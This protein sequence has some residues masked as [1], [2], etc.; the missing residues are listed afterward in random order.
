MRFRRDPKHGRRGE[1]GSVLA[2]STLGMLAFL[3]ATGLCVDVG[4]LYLAKN[5][6]QN[7]ADAAAL[8]GASA[9]NSSAAGITEAKERAKAAM[10]S[11][12]FN[13]VGVSIRDQDVTFA[14]NLGGP[15]ME[16]GNVGASAPSVRF[17]KVKTPP[18][19]V[20]VFFASIV[21]G[22]SR[23][24]TAEATA[25]RSVPITDPCDFLP[26]F[27]ID[28]P[29]VAISPKNVYTFRSSSHVE[30]GNYQILAVAG[31]GGKDV[32]VGIASGVDECAGAGAVY[33]VDTKPGLTS[34]PVRVGI[35]T[36]FDEYQT[37]H[38]NPVDAPPDTNIM[39]DITYDEYKEGIKT[40]APSH[41]GV[42]GR[43]VVII[44]IVKEDQVNNGRDEVQ[45]DRFGL[46][47]LKSKVGNGNGGELQA[48]YIDDTTVVGRGIVGAG[49]PAASGLLTKPVLYK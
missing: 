12:E 17:I 18:S 44:P 46:F 36:R 1:R 33:S 38:V 4:H 43:R 49:P 32:R 6:L 47:F 27:V 26:V 21:L 14:V 13:K 20:K 35:N 42:A 7:A 22:G 28:Y 37:S 2:V 29:G 34:G 25:G 9:L 31:R 19:P 40:K 39:E 5:E 45:F 48:E 15:Y 16:A 41:P 8:A 3:L 24:V 11:Y 30:P 23:D 10:N